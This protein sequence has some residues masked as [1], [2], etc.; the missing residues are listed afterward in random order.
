[1]RRDRL[2]INKSVG[3]RQVKEDLQA[4][5]KEKRTLALNEMEIVADEVYAGATA[6]VPY[7]TWEL[8][9]G[10]DV[11]VSRSPRYPGVIAVATA[12]NPKTNYDYAWIQEV[13]SWYRHKHGRKS[14]YLEVPFEEAVKKF[15]ARVK[16]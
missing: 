12:R 4:L 14:H 2:K 7:K 3:L 15:L 16:W 9:D 5:L 1:M 8:H 6:R 13:S 10:I 11:D